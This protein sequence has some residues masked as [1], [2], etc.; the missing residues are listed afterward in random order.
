M[1][2]ILRVLIVGGLA[3]LAVLSFGLGMAHNAA[4]ILGPAHL[5]LFLLAIV[6]YLAPTGL[7]LYRDSES[8]GWIAA[9]NVLLGWTLFG[10][11]IALGWAAA[12][13]ARGVTDQQPVHSH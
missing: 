10:W 5:L 2:H 3:A 4:A 12:G 9:L 1:T 7:A 11:A 8:L 13:H 6:L